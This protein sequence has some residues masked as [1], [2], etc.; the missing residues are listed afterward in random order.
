MTLPGLMQQHALLIP[1]L[2]DHAARAHRGATIVSLA[3]GAPAHRCGYA[4]VDLRARQLAQALTALGVRPGDRVGT[5]AWNHHRHL[6]L[7]F[8]VSGMGAVLHTVNPRL[9]PEQLAYIIAHAEDRV[10]CVD[11]GFVP[12][13]AALRPQLPQLRHVVVLAPRAAMAGLPVEDAL[14]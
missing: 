13:V 4:D 11:P 10:L 6:E 8:G 7:F 1:S 9:F 3:A 12:L 14:C 5:M 2:L